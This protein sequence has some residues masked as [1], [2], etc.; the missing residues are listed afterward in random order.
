MAELEGV[1]LPAPA[2]FRDDEV[3]PERLAANLHRWNAA[4]VAGYVV[5]GSTG[6]FP[7]LT[8]ADRDRLLVAAREV[9]PREQL[10]IA[11][12]GTNAAPRPSARRGA[13]PNWAPMRPW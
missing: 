13:P 3:A 2:P 10:F 1:F 4:A 6:E 11:G 12:T 9:I 5:L 7:M 8:E